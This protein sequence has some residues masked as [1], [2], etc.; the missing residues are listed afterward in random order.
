MSPDFSLAF[1]SPQTPTQTRQFSIGPTILPASVVAHGDTKF[2]GIP[3]SLGRRVA[4]LGE[5]FVTRSLQGVPREFWAALEDVG[6]ECRRAK[7]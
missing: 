5:L 2:Q 7:S 4:R 6:F 3:M 1:A